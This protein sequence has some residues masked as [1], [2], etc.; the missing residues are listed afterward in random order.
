MYLSFFGLKIK[1][2]QINTN[3]S[4]FWLGEKQKEALTILKY[5]L[6][7]MPGLLLLTGDA[8]TG[9]TT[10]TNVFLDSLDDQYLVVK[11][12]DPDLE[13]IDFINYIA[14]V[15]DFKTKFSSKESFYAHFSR[16]LQTSFDHNQRI[17]LVI[18]ECQRLSSHL[19][20]EIIKLANIAKDGTKLL[21]VLL[22]GQS[23]F[24][25]VLRNNTS[26]ELH[27]LIAINYA[28]TALDG[29]ETGE[30]IRH[31]L[32]TAGANRDIFSPDAIRTVHELSR[33][34]P[35]R[36]NIICD[37]ALLLGFG[38]GNKTINGE[39]IRQCAED[40]RPHN[41]FHPLP[42][43][44]VKAKAVNTPLKIGNKPADT[45]PK[46]NDPRRGKSIGMIVLVMLP[47]FLIVF[48]TN[49][50]KLVKISD[51]MATST[52]P[53]PTVPVEPQTT[54]KNPPNVA[55]SPSIT[56]SQENKGGDLPVVEQQQTNT[57]E[58]TLLQV[59]D[60][61]NQMGDL[62]VD[63]SSG[64]APGLP[65]S[66]STQITQESPVSLPAA[67]NTAHERNIAPVNPEEFDA[68]IEIP[69][70]E[71]PAGKEQD[72]TSEEELPASAL[73][74]QETAINAPPDSS[75]VQPL[76]EEPMAG[77]ELP[78]REA[79]VQEEMPLETIQETPNDVPEELSTPQ[80][81][82]ETEEDR[83]AENQQITD[84]GAVID[85]ILQKRRR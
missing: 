85:Y 83:A 26:R 24:D 11:I 16:F 62:P 23:E 45:R 21:K 4:F 35:V 15:L 79:A 69:Q 37:H 67:E 75:Q 49:P 76:Q 27:Q 10:L 53:A 2:F 6:S 66:T 57:P 56:T 39:L 63:S 12:P 44:A 42:D 64:P 71:S 59:I 30:L 18:D 51:R 54:S 65:D 7:K 1:P 13:D 43:I 38:Q 77:K 55:L 46:A 14:D 81:V 73:A 36:I 25:T 41:Y 9:K 58:D 33:G 82:L 34:I 5:G 47:V 22:I 8:G 80:E 20:K 61:P 70:E 78:E 29:K 32:K 72:R 68:S 84:P 74:E 52:Q 31:R 40:L 28:I 50:V 60:E 19:L 48:L 17:I 3:P